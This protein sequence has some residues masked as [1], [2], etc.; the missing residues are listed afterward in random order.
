MNTIL[1]DKGIIHLMLPFRLCSRWQPETNG[2]KNDVWTKTD[3]DIPKLDFLIEHVKDFFTRNSRSEVMDEAACIIMKLDIKALPAKMFNNKVF[4]LSNR[5]FDTHEKATNLLKFPVFL[6]P[7]SFRLIINPFASIAILLFS[8][9]IVKSGKN[10]ILPNLSDFIQMNYL[11]RLFNRHDEAYLI[12]QNER[13]EER[14]KAAKLSGENNSG[15]FRKD[16]DEDIEHK[17]WRPRHL[18]DYLLADLNNEYKVEFFDHYHFSPVCFVQPLKEITDEDLIHH[19]LF[20]LRKVYDFDYTPATN[21]LQREAELFHPYRQ[22]YYSSS[23][24][25]AV[26]FNNCSP[27]DPEFIRTFYFNSFPKSLWLTVLGFLQRSIFLQLMK[28]VSDIDPDDH[29]KIKEYLK[30]YTTLSL[31]AIFS[32]VSVYHQHND[33]YDLI[34]HNL[35]INELQNE[36]KDELHELNNMQRQFHEDEMERLEEIEKQYDK[37]LNVILFVL[38]VFGL[39]E[40]TYSVISATGMSFFEHSLAIG[41]PV[42]LGII[43]WQVLSYRKKSD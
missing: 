28:E 12:S 3:E 32:K 21:I 34:I 23:L 40:I 24:E 17:G 22:I 16:E 4:W 9:E 18:I 2:S 13:I 27:A 43:F 19:T 33:Y 20:Y 36:L 10:D 15:M 41:I 14:S 6:D 31:K 35:Q 29:Q 1:L 26:V 7:G 25:G 39:T 5:A 42:I 11:L 8:L 37:R 30:R 38:S